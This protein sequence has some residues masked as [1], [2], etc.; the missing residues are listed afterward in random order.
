MEN[1]IQNL[2]NW[3]KESQNEEETNY[4]NHFVD[5]MKFFYGDLDELHGNTNEEIHMLQQKGLLSSNPEN[6]HISSH[7]TNLGILVF[8]S[9]LSQNLSEKN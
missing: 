3:L 4:S 9:F 7:Q 1:R 8:Y 6:E 5:I 2:V